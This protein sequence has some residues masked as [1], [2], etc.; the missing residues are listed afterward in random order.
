MPQQIRA[1][2]LEVDLGTEALKIWTAKVRAY[3]QLAVGG[4]FERLFQHRQF[5]VLVVASS[6]RRMKNIRSV[7]ST[8][9]DKMFWLTTFDFINREGFWSAVWLRP[10]VEQFQSLL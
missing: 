4:E 7:V 3:I 5:R 10:R 2:F 6:E 1:A 8:A 9:T